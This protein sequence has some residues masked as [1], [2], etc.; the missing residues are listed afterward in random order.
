VRSGQ[1]FPICILVGVAFLAQSCGGSTAVENVVG[2]DAARCQTSVSGQPTTVVADGGTVSVSVNAARDCTWTASTESSWMQLSTTSGQGSASLSVTVARN[3]LPSARSGGI[4]VN[5]QRLTVSQEAR[6]CTFD[7]QGTSA[8]MSSDGGR[9]SFSVTAP[10]GCSWTATT[11][12]SWI[13]VIAGSGSGGGTV[14]YEVAANTGG[15]RDATI[16]V[17]DRQHSVSQVGAGEPAPAPPAGAACTATVNPTSIDVPVGGGPATVSLTIN[18]TCDWSASSSDGWVTFTSPSSGRGSATIG[19]QAAANTGAARAA[20]ITIAQQLV[21]ISQQ[22]AAATPTCTYSVAPAS[23]VVG[24]AGGRG[25]FTISTSPGCAWTASKDADWVTLSRTSGTGTAEVSYTHTTNTAQQTRN[26]TITAQ[27]RTHVIRQEAAAPPPPPACTYSIEPAT[28]NIGASGG[29]QTFTIT[30]NRNDCQ[31]SA[32]SDSV[33]ASLGR[34]TGSGTAEITYTVQANSGT[35]SRTATFSLQGGQTHRVTQDATPAPVC[36]YTIAPPSRSVGA[37]A[38]SGSF[39]IATTPEC[40]WNAT[41]DN[42]WVQLSRTSGTGTAEVSYNYDANAGATPRTATISSQGQTHAV[43]QEAAAPQC[44]FTVQPSSR[45]FPA[46]GGSG[47]ITIGTT[48]NCRWD[49]SSNSP[50][51]VLAATT[52]TGPAELAYTVQANATTSSRSATVTAAGQA[53][54]VTQQAAAPTCTFTLDPSSRSF[55]AAGGEGRFNVVTQPGCQWTATNTNGWVSGGTGGGTGPG[56]VVYNVQANAVTAPRS[57]P[58]TVNGVAHTINQEAAAAPPPPPCTYTLNPSSR[59]FPAAGGEGQFTVETQAHCQWTASGAPPWVTGGS[60]STTGTGVVTYTV[61]QNSEQT[62]RSGSITVN[63]QPHAI[64]QEA[65][66]APPPPP[67]VCTYS[68]DPTERVA[69]AIGALGIVR[70]ITGADCAWSVT[71]GA[72]WLRLGSSGGTGPRDVGYAVEPN[73]TGAPRTTAATIAGQTFTVRQ[74]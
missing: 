45:D 26:A 19:L 69:G 72:D 63:G 30:T 23:R 34:T 32:S 52:G 35:S 42:G 1:P 40:A 38:G 46:G 37:T 59:T 66:P 3:E 24:A 56:E 8:R 58:I 25:T 50:W 10:N 36:T 7:L 22:A 54:T 57:G 73:G 39:T 5:D 33:W 28:R 4:V 27:G 64:S 12:A 61:Q 70:V 20:T 68:I 6:P 65:A 18:N 60:A 13:R 31:W 51:V 44:S 9:G 43:V 55:T 67:P 11:S 62:G 49:A 29:S 2:P 74:Q 71:P 41:V 14:Q 48:A 17:A 47:S 15:P 21:V 53:H 16:T